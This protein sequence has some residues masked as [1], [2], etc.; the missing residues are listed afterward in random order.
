MLLTHFLLSKIGEIIVHTLKSCYKNHVSMS[1]PLIRSIHVLPG[2]L[3]CNLYPSA[4]AQYTTAEVTGQWHWMEAPSERGR[5]ESRK[6]SLICSNSEFWGGATMKS[7]CHG[8]IEAFKIWYCCL[9]QRTALSMV[10]GDPRARWPSRRPSILMLFLG[11]VQLSKLP[12]F[13]EG[14]F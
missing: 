12:L 10:L 3:K 11:A 14:W 6:Q 7:L 2:E 5:M 4:H 8:R 9:L 1:Y 13:I